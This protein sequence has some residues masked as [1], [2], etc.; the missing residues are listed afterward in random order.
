MV[1]KKLL[2][3]VTS[4]RQLTGEVAAPGDKSISHRAIILSSLALGRSRIGNLSPGRDCLSTIRCLKKL[5]V[6][7]ASE[8]DETSVLLIQGVGNSGLAEAQDVL[9]AG[10][11]ATT[12]RLL[13]GVL[14]TQP[15][16]S[17]LT[18][19]GSLRSRPMKR[20]IE[21]LRLMGA[22]IHGRDD[23]SFAPLVIKGGRVHGMTYSL[24]VPSAQ[25]KSAVL[26]AGL[27]AEGNTIVEQPQLCR[28]HTERLLR[29]MG[30]KVETDNTHIFLAPLTAPL[31]A[32]DLCMP[33]DISSAACWLV[34]GAIH[35]NARIRITNCG[36]NPTRTGIIDALVD[37]GAKLEVKNQRLDSNEPVADLCIESSQLRAI[38]IG[39]EMVPR[40]IDEIPL[41]AVAACVAK[42]NTVIRGAGELRIKESDRIAATV[43]ELRRL[44]AR[45][46]ELPDGM[47]IYGG[48]FLLGTEVRTHSDHRLAMTLAI[49]GLVAKGDT[50]IH[51]AQVAEISYPAFW[52]ELERLAR[53]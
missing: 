28:D 49:A 15:F 7:F 19:D 25:L 16:L 42:G 8:V 10:N 37:M 50:T 40:L 46:E 11:S 22:E 1:G 38:E 12:M 51:N 24:P 2:K 47:V 35:P 34:G 43:R 45:V 32:I 13:A 18:G 48:K 44:G 17:I 5:G 9:N 52:T 4:P 29:Q 27:F 14:A 30:A 33:G 31:A 36:I 6:G 53:Y 23:D 41:L 39:G 3:R 21:P 26:L 20:L